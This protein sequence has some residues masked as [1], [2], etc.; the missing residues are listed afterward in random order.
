MAELMLAADQRRDLLPPQRLEAPLDVPFADDAPRR[1][2]LGEA[3]QAYSA[4]VG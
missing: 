2:R 3:L 1:V 4:E